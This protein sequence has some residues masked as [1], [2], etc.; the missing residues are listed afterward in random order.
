MSHICAQ[1]IYSGCTTMVHMVHQIHLVS[2][3]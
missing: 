3:P 1:K 2:G